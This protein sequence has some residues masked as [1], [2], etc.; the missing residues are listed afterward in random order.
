M[1]LNRMKPTNLILIATAAAVTVAILALLIATRFMAT[2]TADAADARPFSGSFEELQK[3]LSLE[4]FD[5]IESSGTWKIV[6]VRGSTASVKLTIPDYLESAVIA[7]VQDRKLRLG[8]RPGTTVRSGSSVPRADITAPSL[9]ELETSGAVDA[10]VKGFDE[11]RLR[12]SLSG[13]SILRGEDCTVEELEVETSGAA[14][15]DLRDCTVKNAE[16]EISGAGVMD[17]TMDGGDLEGELSGVAS[18]TYY[19][20]VRRE[21]IERSG[22][23]SVR[24]Q[25]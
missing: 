20:E 12:M 19:G 4:G 9:V 14:R 21:R 2:G 25:E 11:E 22:L 18:L 13:G 17:I 8:F 23:A 16:V 15:I 3:E 1:R 5:R 7:D 10:T 6:V 24:H